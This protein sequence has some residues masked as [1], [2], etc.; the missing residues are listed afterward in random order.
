MRRKLIPNA[1]YPSEVVDDIQVRVERLGATLVRLSYVATG[2]IDRIVLAPPA[3]PLRTDKLWEK[4]CFEAFL[5]PV[6]G[7]SYREFNFSP[8]GQWATYQFS[9]HRKGMVQAALPAPPEI[10]VARESC[11]L[12]IT[13][14]FSP[15]LPFEPYRLGLSAVIEEEGGV[16]SYWAL[17]HPP[18]APDFHDPSCFALELPAA[19]G[20]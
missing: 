2:R 12:G 19:T 17:D 15:D 5:A 3:H 16:R 1:A 4:T 14:T 20:K 11:R 8:S 18:G 7:P 13:V 6:S 10:E 9:A